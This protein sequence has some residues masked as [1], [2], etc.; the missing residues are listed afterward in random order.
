M[1]IIK[2]DLIQLAVAGHFDV[3]IHGCNCF[4]TMEA[5]IALQLKTRFPA[6]LE[7]DARTRPGDREKLGTYTR[8]KVEVKGNPFIVVNGY[9]QFDYAGPGVLVDYEAVAGLFARIK[10]DFTGRRIG[11]PR[12]GAGLAGGDWDRISRLIDR[13][14]SGEDHTLVEFSR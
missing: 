11:Y 9:T 4:C 13:A 12:I 6:V 1:D 8:V 5:G 2:G 3:I 14:L 7:A 10:S